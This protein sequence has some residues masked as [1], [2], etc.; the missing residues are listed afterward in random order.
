[1]DGE[2]GGMSTMAEVLVEGSWPAS[3]SVVEFQA[4]SPATGELLPERRKS[5][6]CV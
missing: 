1:M 6:S 3:R 4:E 2:G 5:Q